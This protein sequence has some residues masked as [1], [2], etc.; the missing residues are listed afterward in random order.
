MPLLEK[1]LAIRGV[2]FE[3]DTP[4][5]PTLYKNCIRIA[6]PAVIEGM[7]LSIINSIDTMMVGSLGSAA[8]A[9]VGL[10]AQPRMILLLLIQA[11][12]AGTTAVVARR[13]GADDPDSANSCLHQSLTIVTIL[14]VIMALLGYFWAVPFMRFSGANSETLDMAVTYFRIIC[15]ALPFN[16]WSLCICAGMRAIGQTKITMTTNIAANLVNVFGNYLLIN[17]HFGFPAWGVRGNAIATSIGTL[18]SCLIAVRFALRRDGYLRLRPSKLLQFDKHTL[19]S[20]FAVGSSTAAESVFLRLGFLINNKLIAGIGTA[21]FAA[22]QI[23]SQIT[24]LSFTIGDGIGTAGAAL[25]GQSLG[26]R[27]KNTALGYIK[28]VRRLSVF[29]SLVLIVLFFALRNQMPLLFTNEQEI[30]T[31]VSLAF[32][33]VCFGVLPQNG[34]VVYAGCLRGAGD[35][36]FVAVCALISVAIVRPFLTYLFCYPVNQAFPALQMAV[37]GPWL[38]FVID[39][40]IR[41]FLLMHRVNSGRWMDIHL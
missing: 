18:V 21:A 40:F 22:N 8:I 27:R 24:S 20:L 11:L 31:G 37:C 32:I 30:I 26:A 4:P 3:E 2:D 29:S 7:L 41:E 23:V 35:V 36:K 39:A 14:A 13:K 25:V 12:C 1:L 5:L 9:A 10:T 38:A 17:G 16:A 6:W 15:L 19:H 33:V 28:I 34:R